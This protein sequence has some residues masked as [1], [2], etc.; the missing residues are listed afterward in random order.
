MNKEEQEVIKDMEEGFVWLV[1][2]LFRRA[3]EAEKP[4]E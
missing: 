1:E 2:D 3:R 4:D